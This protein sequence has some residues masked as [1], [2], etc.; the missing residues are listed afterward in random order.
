MAHVIIATPTATSQVLQ[1]Y[2]Q[3]LMKTRQNLSTHGIANE[4][5][6][7]SF[8]EVHTARNVLAAQFLA[9]AKATH[10]FFID[11]DMSFPSALCREL[12]AMDKEVIG[13]AYPKRT[14]DMKKLEENPDQDSRK[15]PGCAEPD[16]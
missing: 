9:N 11:S 15:S 7:I 8:S 1:A 12:L 10:V 14:L 16:L 5:V 13:A 3:T 4:Y 6:S 2:V